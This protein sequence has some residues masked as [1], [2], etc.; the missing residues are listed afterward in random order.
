MTFLKK[1]WIY[2][3]TTLKQVLF[4]SDFL[5][6]RYSDCWYIIDHYCIM[7]NLKKN[8]EK[9]KTLRTICPKNKK[10]CKNCK[11]RVQFYWF[12]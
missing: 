1:T 3:G 11:P 10:N 6:H 9:I 4:L 5:L 8:R 2:P 7:R 12:L